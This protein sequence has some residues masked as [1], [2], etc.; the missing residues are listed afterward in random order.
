MNGVSRIDLQSVLISR[1][2]SSD[3]L[4]R[5]TA[6]ASGTIDIIDSELN[7]GGSSCI[8]AQGAII[9]TMNNV[10]LESCSGA[11]LWAQGIEVDITGLEIGNESSIG[12]DLSAVSGMIADVDTTLHDGVNVAIRVNLAEDLKLEN[13]ILSAPQDAALSITNSKNVEIN[14]LDMLTSP[15][16][17]MDSTTG[18]FSDMSIDCGGSGTAISIA[19]LRTSGALSIADSEISS[20]DTGIEVTSVSDYNSAV[21]FSDLEIVATITLSVDGADIYIK[22][23]TFTGELQC[24]NATVD[25]VNIE[26]TTTTASSGEIWLWNSHII[27][28][29]LYGDAVSA[30][31]SVDNGDGGWS[32][33]FSGSST[34]LLFPYAIISSSGRSDY[35]T[36]SFTISAEGASPMT[37]TLAVGPTAD[38]IITISLTGNSPPSVVILTPSGESD[39]MEG[40]SFTASAEVSDDISPFDNLIIT[41]RLSDDTGVLV[42]EQNGL[43]ANFTN[44]EPGTFL[45]TLFAEDQQG[46][47]NTTSVAI[48]VSLLDSDGDWIDTCNDATWFDS[49]VGFSCGPDVYDE[50]DDNDGYYDELDEWPTDA[51]A[52]LDTDRDG[53]PNTID[54]PEGHTTLLVEDQDDDNDGT[55]DILEGAVS[56]Q[57]EGSSSTSLLLGIGVIVIL[58]GII[59]SRMRKEE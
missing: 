8:E 52:A 17:E 3:P 26:P 32:T 5:T 48:E 4:I 44:L 12:L 37:Q 30:S 13:L 18:G 54:C 7:Q 16:I 15:G 19:S 23:G 33:E 57:D 11:A 55:P 49:L 21:T 58:A 29:T 56:S 36:A 47:V 46:A 51:C 59:F 39:L 38:D 34:E 35:V 1:S 10:E 50:D 24:A 2:G 31:F 27:Q 42:E 53:Q 6:V 43:T 20:C 28:A 40:G 14:G 45:L 22:S 9:L 41:W 25:L